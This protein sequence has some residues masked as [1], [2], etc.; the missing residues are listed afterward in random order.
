MRQVK[1]IQELLAMLLLAGCAAD[2]F[3]S[4]EQSI[5]Q[6][7]DQAPMIAETRSV[8]RDYLNNKPSPKAFAFSPEKGTN[9]AAWGYPSVEAAKERAMQQCKERT[10]TQCVLFAVN[11]QIVWQPDNER[12]LALDDKHPAPSIGQF[13]IHVASVHNADDVPGEWQRLASRYQTLAGLEL[14]ASKMVDLLG[15]G[16]FYRVIGGAFT[17]K[18]EAQRV[19]ERLSSVGGYCTVVEL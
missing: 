10:R 7:I 6:R 17:T 5:E 18:T 12:Q 4:L 11:D 3:S 2:Q 1:A 14:Q 19:C 16:I 13:A 15:K 8:A 9:W